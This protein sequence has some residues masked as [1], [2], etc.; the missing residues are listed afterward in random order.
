VTQEPTSSLGTVASDLPELLK[1]VQ[2]LS[3]LPDELRNAVAER[4]T[5]RTLAAGEWL[6]HQ[7]DV[8]DAMFLVLSGRLEVVL[9]HPQQEVVRVMGRGGVVGE[10]ALLTEAPRSAGIRARRDTEL[11]ALDRGR[12]VELLTE[13]APFAMALTREIGMQLRASRSLEPPSSDVPATIALVA[14]VPGARFDELRDAIGTAL[15]GCDPIAEL[16]PSEHPESYGPMLDMAERD[17]GRVLLPTDNQ[18]DADAW[19]AFCLR[20]S[21]RVVVVAEEDGPD[22]GV[23]AALR[24]ADLLVLASGDSPPASIALMDAVEPR[25]VHIVRRGPDFQGDVARAARRLSG[26]SVGVVLSGGGARGFCHIGVLGELL[27]AGLQID[28]V[29][30]CSMGAYVGGMCAI[31][32]DASAMRDRCNEEFVMHSITSDYTIP[33]ASLL[34]G[35]RAKEAFEN[36]FGDAR[37]ET[38]SREFFCV[39]ADLISGELVEHRSGLFVEEVSASA[40][41]PGVYRPRPLRNRLLVDGG[42]LNN[43]PVQ[44]MVARGEGPVIAVD[45]TADFVAPERGSGRFRRPRARAWATRARSLVI[46]A[47]ELVP[48]FIETL[49]RSVSVGSTAAV[50][51]ARERADALIAPDTGTVPMLDFA[52][53]DEMIAIG[54]RAA[55]DALAA[56]K[57]LPGL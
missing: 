42:V 26:R 53:L 13:E 18:D 8:G 31:E 47:D 17:C 5:I 33:L 11:L 4:A 38:A 56:E 39:S 9:E 48:S 15:Q 24:G 44:Q 49:V 30:G 27:E 32:M 34:R 51:A 50:S 54:R 3:G 40:C 55:A 6:F 46:G 45:V 25:T 52:R 2:V 57:P 1:G 29:G 10:L 20:Q 43:L 7:G 19:T 12:F 28:R 22:V 21:D 35:G 23:P 14:L 37:I 41:L 36:T 16:M